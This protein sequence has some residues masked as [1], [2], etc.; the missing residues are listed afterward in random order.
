MGICKNKFI[1]SSVILS[2]M[3][4]Y[5]SWRGKTDLE[6]VVRAHVHVTSKTVVA[7]LVVVLCS[8][9]KLGKTVMVMQARLFGGS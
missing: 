4:I 6:N 9:N 7:G 1:D 8:L 5:L 3:G 2:L